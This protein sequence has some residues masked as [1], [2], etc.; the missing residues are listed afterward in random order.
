MCNNHTRNKHK[1]HSIHY[2]MM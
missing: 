2:S 1:P